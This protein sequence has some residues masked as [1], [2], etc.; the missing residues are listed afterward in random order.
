M[1]DRANTQINTQLVS[2]LGVVVWTDKACAE[3]SSFPALAKNAALSRETLLFFMSLQS[4]VCG[5]THYSELCNHF[6]ASVYDCPELSSYILNLLWWDDNAAE[7]SSQ[8]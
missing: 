6:P 3:N 8:A 4:E 1:C 2:P 7:V 5:N